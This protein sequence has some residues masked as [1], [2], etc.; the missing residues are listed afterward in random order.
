MFAPSIHLPSSDAF[1][2]RIVQI[3]LLPRYDKIL[4]QLALGHQQLLAVH[5]FRMPGYNLEV[6]LPKSGETD[7]D[8]LSSTKP[9]STSWCTA[10]QIVHFPLFGVFENLKISSD[11]Q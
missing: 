1:P 3:L 10:A 9:T 11:W 2:P 8:T 7:R 5:E 6:N 4:V